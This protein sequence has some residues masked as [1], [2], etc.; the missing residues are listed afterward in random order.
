[1]GQSTL[2]PMLYNLEAQG[3]IKAQWRDGESGRQ[4][5]YYALT[6]AGKRRLA[7]DTKQWEVLSQ[8]MMALG[9]LPQGGQA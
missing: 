3:L 1:M 6:A 8:A 2:Y 7:A 9:I 4:R 5:K